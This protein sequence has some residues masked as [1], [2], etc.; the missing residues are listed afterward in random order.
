VKS[1]GRGRDWGGESERAKMGPLLA[2]DNS[3]D[4]NVSEVGES[5]YENFKMELTRVHRLII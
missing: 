1:R 2:V 4:G 3:N 5:N